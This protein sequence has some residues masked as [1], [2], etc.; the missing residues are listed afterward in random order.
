M[1]LHWLASALDSGP[2][3]VPVCH[4][5]KPPELLGRESKVRDT[6][7]GGILWSA[8]SRSRTAPSRVSEQGWKTGQEL[9]PAC[10]A[11]AVWSAGPRFS[12]MC[13]SLGA[14]EDFQPVNHLLPLQRTPPGQSCGTSQHGQDGQPGHEE[15]HAA[16]SASGVHRG[17]TAHSRNHSDSSCYRLTSSG[18]CYSFH[19]WPRLHYY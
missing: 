11:R 18:V 14:C 15:P 13:D 8:S 3:L 9:L 4:L 7:S 10:P 12:A 2:L 17:K 16:P 1:Y 6:C 5:E 19:S